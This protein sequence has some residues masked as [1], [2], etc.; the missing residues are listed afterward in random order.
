M[1]LTQNVT[2]VAPRAF[3][4]KGRMMTLSVLRVL[5]ADLGALI[6]Q[7]DAKIETAPALFNNLPVLLDFAALPERAQ[8]AFEIGRLDRLLR[9]RS[10]VPVGLT[11][12]GAVLRGIAA[13]VGLGMISS[14]LAAAPQA[15]PKEA[16]PPPPAPPVLT[17]VLIREPVR[18]GQQVYAR[19]GDLTVLATVSSG[20][21]VMADGNIHIY[22]TLRGRALAG[23][24]GNAEARI[25]CLDLD[26][27][28][29][30]IAGRYQT[31]EQFPVG[32][33]KGPVQIYLN[34]KHLVI[35][36]M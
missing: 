3:E 23:A 24:R 4:L 10:F 32:R 14:G 29:V 25:F 21:E 18:S 7:L 2:Q 8:E 31:S 17:N 11:G 5:S 30:S 26:A 20:A 19:G 16:P 6:T 28:I 27:E 35:E 33:K 15:V 22:G 1:A 12:A 36:S 13:G 34:G 9:E